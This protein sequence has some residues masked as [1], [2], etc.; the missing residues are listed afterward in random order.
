MGQSAVIVVMALMS[1]S[2]Y[3]VYPGETV[4]SC[5]GSRRH[6]DLGHAALEARYAQGVNGPRT[7]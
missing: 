4:Y 2:S 1:M 5:P 6:P 3:I 7:S